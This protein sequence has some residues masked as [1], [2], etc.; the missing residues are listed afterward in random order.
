MIKKLFF[1][2]PLVFLGCQSP[3]IAEKIF[4]NDEGCNPSYFYNYASKH[5]DKIVGVGIAPRNFNGEAAQ[6][7]SAISKAL[8][9]IAMQ[10]KVQISTVTQTSTHA[11]NKN[12]NRSFNSYSIQTVN[13][14]VV[15]AKIVKSCKA[16]DGNFYVVMEAY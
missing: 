12:V 15:H 14:E 5:P 2:L 8:N 6:R 1:L 11:V 9:E 16:D 7:K 13:G 3:E 10:K 4:N